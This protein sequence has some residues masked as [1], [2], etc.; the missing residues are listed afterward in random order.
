MK[1]SQLQKKAE[2][3]GVRPEKLDK[4]ELVRAT[5]MAEGYTPCFG[6]SNGKCPYTDC[7]FINDCRKIKV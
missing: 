3:L 4:I 2:S 1:M 5:Q 6:T 7:C